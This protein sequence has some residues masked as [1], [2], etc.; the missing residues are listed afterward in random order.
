MN[1][2][3]TDNQDQHAND[4]HSQSATNMVARLARV[5]D[6]PFHPMVLEAT[7]WAVQW[8][9]LVGV[10]PQ[11]TLQLGS[12]LSTK[13]FAVLLDMH[14]HEAVGVVFLGPALALAIPVVATTDENQPRHTSDWLTTLNTILASTAQVAPP[15]PASAAE[16]LDG[17]VVTVDPT[18][19]WSFLQ[20]NLTATV[21]AADAA[22]E[23]MK[24]SPTAPMDAMSEAEQYLTMLHSNPQEPKS[25]HAPEPKR[26][27]FDEWDLAEIP[28][29]KH[30][31]LTRTTSSAIQPAPH[32]SPQP[33]YQP[34]PT[35]FVLVCDAA[36]HG[37]LALT[38]SVLEFKTFQ[39]FNPTRLTEKRQ[40]SLP[41][42][43]LNATSPLAVLDE[44]MLF[45]AEAQRH[46]YTLKFVTEQASKATLP[47]L[48]A[49]TSG[50]DMAAGAWL[51]M[52]LA[53]MPQAAALKAIVATSG[54]STLREIL[55][56]LYG[57][58]VRR[59]G[60]E[61][62]IALRSFVAD[63]SVTVYANHERF[64]RLAQA[65]AGVTLGDAVRAFFAGFKESRALLRTRDRWEELR[66]SRA[67]SLLE[68]MRLHEAY[69]ADEP[70]TIRRATV[71]A[72]STD[73]PT[74]NV[75]FACGSPDHY[76][77]DCPAN[78]NKDP[79]RQPPPRAPRPRTTRPTVAAL[80]RHAP[81]R[82][83][84][85]ANRLNFLTNKQQKAVM[86]WM[87]SQPNPDVPSP[88]GGAQ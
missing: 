20:R 43:S 50:A 85:S 27:R 73:T 69:A 57:T 88:A 77:R 51:N 47:E 10:T 36:R 34:T 63:T 16:V 74:R 35:D 39:E 14:D 59:V 11:M 25:P 54:A 7:T 6:L 67:V 4:S 32:M 8:T 64:L 5:F 72:V 79:N 82:K 13:G 49:G 28:I 45:A 38:T 55:Q 30:P 71:A 33:V 46:G 87:R 58:V 40:A 18:P 60:R 12:V 23:V 24:L 62:A 48:A 66:R 42:L 17:S 3:H 80:P 22:T 68:V 84:Q 31:S 70:V 41:N 65:A 61:A 86:A 53:V 26:V 76:I 52:S 83:P 75:C 9:W 37:D 15:T 44:F 19:R 29:P 21:A 56:A 78:N 1:D 81:K 2:N